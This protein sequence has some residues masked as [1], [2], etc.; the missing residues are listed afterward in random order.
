MAKRAAEG[1]MDRAKPEYV[2]EAS[3]SQLTRKTTKAQSK[4]SRE[5]IRDHVRRGRR[6]RPPLEGK[7]RRGLSYALWFEKLVGNVSKYVS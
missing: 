4:A 1:D 2:V 7:P 3:L 6:Y 5:R